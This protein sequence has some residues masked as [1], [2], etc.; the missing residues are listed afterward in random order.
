MYNYERME[1][2]NA[3]LCI[4]EFLDFG[5]KKKSQERNHKLITSFDSSFIRLFLLITIYQCY[6]NFD[7][8]FHHITE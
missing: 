7:N 4:N 8:S 5:G 3:L 6:E 1:I 2:W